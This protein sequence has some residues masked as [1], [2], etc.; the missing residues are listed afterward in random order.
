MVDGPTRR[1]NPYRKEGVRRPESRPQ[2]L[3]LR[4]VS[5]RVCFDVLIRCRLSFPGTFSLSGSLRPCTWGEGASVDTE[6]LSSNRVR[7]G[8]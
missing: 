6:G 7:K 8:F 2:D 5:L 1:Q 3:L 4:C